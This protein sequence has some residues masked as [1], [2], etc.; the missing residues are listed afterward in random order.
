PVQ[1]AGLS[2]VTSLSCIGSVT[3]YFIDAHP[4]PTGARLGP[5]G[6]QLYYGSG[7]RPASAPFSWRVRLIR[8]AN[9]PNRFLRLRRLSRLLIL[10]LQPG[11]RRASFVTNHLATRFLSNSNPADQI[12]EAS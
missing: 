9:R 2:G 6:G 10:A 5:W 12:R 11:P 7:Q 1:P 3:N 8:A 4:P